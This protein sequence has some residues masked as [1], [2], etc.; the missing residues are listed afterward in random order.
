MRLERVRSQPIEDWR[1]GEALRKWVTAC[2]NRGINTQGFLFKL[3]SSKL[4]THSPE[5]K[6]H[7]FS[8]HPEVE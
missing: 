1:D 6:V 7:F 4:R 2:K 5:P 3:L 8:S